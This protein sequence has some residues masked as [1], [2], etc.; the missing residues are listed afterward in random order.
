MTPFNDKTPGCRRILAQQTAKQQDAVESAQE[1]LRLAFD[2]YQAGIDP[3]LNVLTA[4]TTL[5]AAQ[6]TLAML[7][8]QRM[9]S[10]VQ[11]ITAL[12]GG[13]DRSQLPQ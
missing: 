10:I 6:Q 7:Q 8:T 11:L 5:L 3:Y 12:G 1:F 9:T 2:R 4:Q 13:W